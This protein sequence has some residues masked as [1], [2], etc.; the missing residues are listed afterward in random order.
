MPAENSKAYR[1]S[2]ESVPNDIFNTDNNYLQELS[3]KSFLLKIAELYRFILSKWKLLL[4]WLVIGGLV[5]VCYSFT[6]QT[7][8]VARCRFVLDESG[9]NA[10]QYAGIAS[11][12]GIDLGGNSSGLFQGDNILELYKSRPMVLKTLLTPAIFNGRKQLLIDKFI[13]FNKL[14]L[15]WNENP[16]LKLVNFNTKSF[17]RIQ[18]SL[19]TQIIGD[20]DKTYL[21]V[22]RPDRKTGIIAVEV[23]AQDEQFA[24]VFNEQ[25]VKNVNDFYIQTKTT[26]SQH[27][28]AA[29]ER[30]E[31]TIRRSF[32]KSISSI[33]SST[34]AN[35]NLNLARQAIK[36]P[37]QLKQVNAETSR[38]ILAELVKN[39]EF[40]KLSLQRE[41]PL[42]Q[43][44][45]WPVYPLEKLELPWQRAFVEVALLFL[46]MAGMILLAKKIITDILA[47]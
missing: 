33:A 47:S 45:D 2:S 37:S 11:M 4:L 14:R 39:I 24:K 28:L 25:I 27:A 42:I 15:K 44:V 30:Q 41:T 7:T 20:I 22:S 38:A 29:L 43:L 34:D 32:N 1:D 35:I 40:T 3:F 18:D 6:K 46:F 8:Y 19:V 26:K 23:K 16:K 10:S 12:I 5:G 13:E 31:D 36:V 9:G 21:N 17:S